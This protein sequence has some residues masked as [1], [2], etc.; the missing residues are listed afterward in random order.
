MVGWRAGG[1]CRGLNP[2]GL[3]SSGREESR[4]TGRGGR[5]QAPG[6]TT[7][8]AARRPAGTGGGSDEHVPPPPTHCSRSALFVRASLAD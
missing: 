2:T 7:P 4:G 3:V 6:E 5:P 8:A 1:S